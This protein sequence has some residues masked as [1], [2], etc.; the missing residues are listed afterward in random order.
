MSSTHVGPPPAPALY[1]HVL[2]SLQ[3]E[4][5]TFNAFDISWNPSIAAAYAITSYIVTPLTTTEGEDLTINCPSSCSPVIP[6]PCTGLAV[7]ERVTVNISAVNC[8]TQEGAAV[9]VT[10]ASCTCPMLK[11]NIMISV[12]HV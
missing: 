5:A 8:D 10:I 9:A 12:L 2:I 7:G 1:T 3:E 4:N 6:C 11:L